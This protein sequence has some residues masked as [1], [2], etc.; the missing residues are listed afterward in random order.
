M[1]VIKL[2]LFVVIISIFEAIDVRIWEDF[3]F[4]F[5]ID[6]GEVF[7]IVI[8]GLSLIVALVSLIVILSKFDDSLCYFYL[9]AGLVV[10]S[11]V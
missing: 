6:F 7:W 2:Y 3:R 5:F 4:V 1:R 10:L 9:V 11:I 8:A